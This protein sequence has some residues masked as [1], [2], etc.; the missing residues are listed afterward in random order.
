MLTGITGKKQLGFE[1]I[2]A[3]FSTLKTTNQHFFL[4][5]AIFFQHFSFP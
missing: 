1:L 2:I 3:A 4:N 5:K